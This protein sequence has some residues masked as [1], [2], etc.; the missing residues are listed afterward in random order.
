MLIRMAEENDY[1][2]L[3]VMK[4]M[5]CQE[6]DE[7]YGEKNLEGVDKQCFIDSF[8]DFLKTQK[9]YTIFV[10]EENETILSSMFVSIIPKVPK[11]NE[12]SQSIAYLTNVYTL[13]EYRNKRIG[14]KLLQYI[15]DYLKEC[16]CELAIVWPSHN[17]VE[18]Y[19]R[20]GFCSENEILECLFTAG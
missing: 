14:T 18:W 2:Q 11:P 16:D 7:D 15:K 8:V 5:H 19:K 9:F 4:W 12:K 10:I 6:D 1:M 17:S 3:A 13:K 20:N